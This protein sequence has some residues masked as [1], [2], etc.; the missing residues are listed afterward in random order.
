MQ[1]KAKFRTRALKKYEKLFNKSKLQSENISD[2]YY[3][4]KNHVTFFNQLEINMKHNKDIKHFKIMNEKLNRRVSLLSESYTLSEEDA[5]LHLINCYNRDDI[6]VTRVYWNYYKGLYTA[7]DPKTVQHSVTQINTTFHN[8]VIKLILWIY[9]NYR[10]FNERRLDDIK[11]EISSIDI[12]KTLGR[13]IAT[14]NHTE[15]R[16]WKLCN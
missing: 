2:E 13:N 3:T 8:N 4:G 1:L 10:Q 9:K 16:L 5:K 14:F 12:T 7:L 11:R 15:K 6:L